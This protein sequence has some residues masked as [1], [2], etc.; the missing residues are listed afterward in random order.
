M[1]TIIDCASIITIVRRASVPLSWTTVQVCRKELFM[2]RVYVVLPESKRAR[3]I[4][5]PERSMHIVNTAAA[6]SNIYY[7]VSSRLLQ[8]CRDAAGIHRRDSD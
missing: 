4:I 2:K 3:H 5:L 6:P 8:K 1:L 7:L